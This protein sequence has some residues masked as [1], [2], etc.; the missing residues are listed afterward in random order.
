MYVIVYVFTHASVYV[1]RV[2]VWSRQRYMGEGGGGEERSAKREIC[3]EGK[4]RDPLRER[5]IEG[6]GRDPLRERCI[7]GKG[8]DPLRE[9]E[10]DA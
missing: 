6:K 5:R 3:I 7:E 8:R 4:R 10:R 2:C 1:C 9:R